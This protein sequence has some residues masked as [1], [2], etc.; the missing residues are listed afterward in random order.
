MRTAL[1]VSLNFNPGHVSHL[2]ASYHQF[3][4]LGYK[5]YYYVHPAFKEFLPKDSRILFY[6]NT[7]PKT[8]DVAIIWF[9]SQKNLCIIKSLKRKFRTKIIYCYHEPVT[10]FKEYRESGYTSIQVLIERMKDWIGAY[11]SNISDI[12]ILPSKKAYTNYIEGKL[13]KNKNVIYMP[14]LYVDECVESH[15]QIERR[16]F[17]YIGTVA[18]DHSFTEYL[19]FV[20]C[21]IM[22]DWMPRIKF[23]IATK[24]EFDIPD[25]IASSSRV[26]IYKG[27]PMSNDEINAHYASSYIVWNAYART[28]QSGVLAKS[29]MFGTPAIVLS[30]NLSEFTEDGA[31][32]VAINDNTSFYEICSSIE[33]IISDYDYF[34]MNARK[35]FENT[36]Y[37]RRY[38]EMFR[39]IIS[40][41]K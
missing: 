36:F 40:S 10:S 11:T 14:L 27:K 13:Y 24:S 8:I 35:R 31:N 3:E 30:K 26:D 23:L 2:Q 5:S 21:A 25:I 7:K 6:G 34:S 17:S 20:E 15:R 41:I 22:N 1:I 9:P 33:K 38:N 39:E 4:D 16:Y 29:F 18:S 19:K 32:I 37:Y 28:T 12:V